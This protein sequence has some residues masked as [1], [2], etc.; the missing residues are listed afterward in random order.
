MAVD[1]RI[2]LVNAA[3][4]AAPSSVRRGEAIASRH[5][6]GTGFARAGESVANAWRT[7]TG[8]VGAMSDPQAA[9]AF[10]LRKLRPSRKKSSTFLP[11]RKLR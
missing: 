2:A 1:A 8:A 6:C 3:S 4:C 10:A 11:Q 9:V 5:D 7:A